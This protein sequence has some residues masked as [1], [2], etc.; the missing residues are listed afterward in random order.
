MSRSKPRVLSFQTEPSDAESTRTT[1]VLK[2][3]S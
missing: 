1:P 2:P 3:P